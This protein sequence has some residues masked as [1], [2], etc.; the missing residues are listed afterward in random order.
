MAAQRLGLR[1]ILWSAW[2]KDWTP[3]ATAATVLAELDRDLGPGVTVLLHDS[4]CASAPGSWRAALGALPI[5]ADR[6]ADRDLAAGPL[7][8]HGVRAA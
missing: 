6:L 8:E 4:D 2:G 3:Q 5:L 7:A 1:T